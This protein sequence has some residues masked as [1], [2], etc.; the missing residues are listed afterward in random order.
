MAETVLTLYSILQGSLLSGFLFGTAL[1]VLLHVYKLSI[2]LNALKRKPVLNKIKLMHP[3]YMASTLLDES[4][5]GKEVSFQGDVKSRKFA[6][7]PF[8]L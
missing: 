3:H 8:E 2:T 6:S 1:T 7:V 5:D 4:A